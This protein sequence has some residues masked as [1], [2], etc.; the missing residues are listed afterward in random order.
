MVT[1]KSGTIV[2]VGGMMK[3]MSR[4][5]VRVQLPNV[6]SIEQWEETRLEVLSQGVQFDTSLISFLYYSVREM[7]GD[8]LRITESFEWKGNLKVMYS[9]SSTMNTCTFS[10]I[11]L[12]RACPALAGVSPGMGHPQSIFW[13]KN[14]LEEEARRCT[15]WKCMWEAEEEVAEWGARLGWRTCG[16]GGKGEIQRWQEPMS[17]NSK[18]KGI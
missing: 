16:E 13:A 8:Y 5:G 15:A 6:W 1:R 14:K 18:K 2:R 9:N 17:G 7:E 12:S 3:M 10:S 11:R 4:W